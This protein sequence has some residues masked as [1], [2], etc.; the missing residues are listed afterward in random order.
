MLFEFI[1]IDDNGERYRALV[2]LNQ[3]ERIIEGENDKTIIV[4]GES[5]GLFRAKN[6]AIVVDESYQSIKSR[7]N[8][9]LLKERTSSSDGVFEEFD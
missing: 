6:R 5:V 7:L 2:N 1:C 9:Y 4:F 3:I 8:C